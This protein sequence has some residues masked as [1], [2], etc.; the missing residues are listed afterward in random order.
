[1][2]TYIRV[3]CC[4]LSFGLLEQSANADPPASKQN[5][6]E[7][8]SA[9]ALLSAKAIRVRPGFMLTTVASEPNLANPVA[10]CFDPSGRIFVAETFRIKKG[11]QDDRDTPEWLDDDLACRTVADRREYVKR[12]MGD[13]IGEFTKFSDQVRLLTDQDADGIYET[14]SIF[15]TGY[16]NIEDGAAAGVLWNKDR[17]LFSCI[18][19][20]WE[21]HDADHDGV[22][23]QKRAMATGFGVHYALIGHDLH[24]L[25]QGPDGM[26][27][28]S[29]GD[30]GFN[31]DGPE[32]K[33]ENTNSGAVL[34]FNPDGSHLEIFAT[35]LR[36]PQE[37]AF[38]EFGDLF[39]V[40][41]NSD[42]GDKARLVHIVEGMDAGW[43]MSF[44]YLDDR[45]PFNREKIWHTQ[46]SEQ[47]ASI[48]PPLAHIS[49]GPSGLVHY[50]GTGLPKAYDGAFFLADF[51]GGA[52]GSGV[53][54]FHVEP[55]G[56]TY[57]LRDYKPFVTNVL[58]TDCDFGPSGDFYVLDWIEGWDGTGKGRIHR[59]RS[60]DAESAVQRGELQAAMQKIAGAL[61]NELVALLSHPNMRVRMAAQQQLVDLG[62]RS[63]E[64]LKALAASNDAPMLGRLHAIWALG[65]LAETD[66]KLFDAIAE[67]CGDKD[68][69][70]RAQGA[71]TLARAGRCDKQ[72]RTAYGEVLAR[73]LTDSSVRVRCL[74]AIA[75]GRLRYGGAFPALLQQ[76]AEDGEDPTLRHAIA[77]ALAGGQSSDK[78]ADVAKTSSALQ[79]LIL[80]VA[81][82]KQKSPLVAQF[83]NDKD[84][85]VV[86]EAARIICDAPVP[87][88]N[89]PLAALIETVPSSAD[90][91]LRR[92]LAA[93]VAEGGPENLQAVI[94]LTCR[95]DLSPKLREL[96]W[97]QIRHW[98][99]PS[100]RDSVIGNWRPLKQ[101]PA[102][103]LTT[104]LRHAWPK[105]V[106]T[107]DKNSLG[108]IVAAELGV[109]EAYAHVLDILSN[110]AHSAE[111]QV[112]AVTAIG[113]ANDD[114]VAQA[115]KIALKSRDATVRSVARELMAERFPKQA[116]PIL[117]EALKN[118]TMREQQAAIDTLAGLAI[119]AAEGVIQEFVGQ[120]ENGACPPE[121]QV[122]VLEAAGKSKNAALVE[123]QKHLVDKLA[124][125]GATSRYS[126]CLSGGDIARGKTVF[127]TD[128]H[129]CRRCHSVKRGEVLVGPCLAE[130][131]SLRKPEEILE[132]IVAPNAK[133]CEGFETAVLQLDNGK[134][135]SGIIRRESDNAIELVD[136]EANTVVVDPKTV[137]RRIKGA[138][139]M[140]ANLM[141][142]MTPRQLR[143]VIAYLSQLKAVKPAKAQGNRK[144]K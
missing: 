28:V 120:L 142:T 25:C 61:P 14:S 112:R 110:D 127:E 68:P 90:P 7:A 20:V 128:T 89:A 144:G 82:G 124:S 71:R 117:T 50:P 94:Q 54:E 60:D 40:D 18:P 72:R 29:I 37:L 43:R 77:T 56:A 55:Q 4:V 13:K 102:E 131:G 33:L 2:S 92:V 85:R 139:P 15:S 140:P 132:S 70:I 130:V 38:N 63:A 91:L 101:R 23:D 107:I 111:V 136:A 57:R 99:T 73:L 1:M 31:I 64:L 129:A 22:A 83:L 113:K 49:S 58:A 86:L 69:E 48:V 125:G 21:L 67:R 106:E 46:N 41:N 138:S 6:S 115:A 123:R 137:E 35:G 104:A 118:G 45:G 24:G 16:N 75:L 34:R 133:I 98:A 11:V 143:D 105:L 5:Q 59:V 134:V 9:P 27:Y 26:V 78:L 74:A 62:T 88:A 100:P 51:H 81:L 30:R 12:R 52:T 44:Q 119:P 80:V 65:Q 122:E 79:R 97:N 32:G 95:S 114:I 84:D 126:V 93:N 36:N 53:Y 10:F 109:T 42:S 3:G 66:P 103:E 108:L 8:V 76:A 135:V 96:A 47:P 17:L 116:V 121:L 19:S 39:T 141:E 87:T